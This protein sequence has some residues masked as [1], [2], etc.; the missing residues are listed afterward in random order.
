MSSHIRTAAVAV[1][2]ISLAGCSSLSLPG[3]G[4]FGKKGSD[5]SLE[6]AAAPEERVRIPVLALDQ[7]LKVN[8]ALKSAGFQLP[9]AAPRAD[10]PLAGGN[11]EQAVEHVEAAPAFK[12]AWR[13]DIG[14]DSNNIQH[15]TAPPIVALAASDPSP[16]FG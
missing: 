8:D 14:K 2:A 11:P 7:Q 12:I 9:P 13:R 3:M 6:G 1:L 16:G 15:I 5:D 4:I 10:W